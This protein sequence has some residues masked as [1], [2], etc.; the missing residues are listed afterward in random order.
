MPSI[1]YKSGGDIV[2]NDL[3]EV[4]RVAEAVAVFLALLGA[5]CFMWLL[6]RSARSSWDDLM[7]NLKNS[8]MPVL[9][10]IGYGYIS[11]GM[12][13]SS[14]THSVLRIL[15]TGS[16]EIFSNIYVP[17]GSTEYCCHANQPANI[18]F[19]QTGRVSPLMI[20]P[21]AFFILLTFYLCKLTLENKI[22]IIFL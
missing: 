20:L 18:Y 5:C 19:Q 7:V 4:Y 12:S 2:E 16:S 14:V 15:K 3:I 8:L 6:K 9:T 21:K 1:R 22:A 10:Y 13:N 17:Y 11:K